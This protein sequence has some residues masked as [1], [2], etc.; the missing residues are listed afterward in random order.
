[1]P[2]ILDIDKAPSK[3]LPHGRGKTIMLFSPANGLKNVDVHINVLN[4]GVTK[5]AIHYHKKIENVYVVLEGEGMIEDQH[6]KEYSVKAGQAIFFR[7]G[8]PPDTHE[9]YNT[10]KGFLRLVEIYA[11]PHPNDAYLEKAFDPS[12]RDHVIVKTTE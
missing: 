7:P 3:D 12:K 6:G 10:G 8:E 11:P 1:M 9:I 5:G 2:V 4:P